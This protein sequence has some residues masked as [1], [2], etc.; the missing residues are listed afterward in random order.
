MST[1]PRAGMGLI[2]GI[3]VRLPARESEG[4]T[5]ARPLVAR[6]PMD[7][8]ASPTCT[9]RVEL[10]TAEAVHSASGATKNAL[11]CGSWVRKEYA[12]VRRLDREGDS[13]PVAIAWGRRQVFAG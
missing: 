7:L 12:P 8:H 1:R 6:P 13:A 3:C 10:A 5:C 2:E 9:E 11:C 4:R